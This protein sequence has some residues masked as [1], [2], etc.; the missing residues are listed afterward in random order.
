MRCQVTIIIRHTEEM[1]DD[2]RTVC[3]GERQRE[4]NTKRQWGKLAKSEQAKT[5]V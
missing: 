3:R 4:I 5:A 2:R 1:R